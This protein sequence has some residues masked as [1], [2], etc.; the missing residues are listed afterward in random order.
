MNAALLM[1]GLIQAPWSRGR[2]LP[3]SSIPDTASPSWQPFLSPQAWVSR[4]SSLPPVKTC[5]PNVFMSLS[6]CVYWIS[7]NFHLLLSYQPLQVGTIIIFMLPV[8][9]LKGVQ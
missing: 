3:R 9:E 8:R 2:R 4:S 6:V 5:G 1:E 7:V